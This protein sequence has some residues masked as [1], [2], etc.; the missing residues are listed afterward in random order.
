MHF[1]LKARQA[2]NALRACQAHT[3]QC[4]EGMSDGQSASSPKSKDPTDIDTE[5]HG[6]PCQTFMAQ[7]LNK[8][9]LIMVLFSVIIHVLASTERDPY[10]KCCL[11][12]QP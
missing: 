6:G 8:F 9:V 12:L 1:A 3:A 2:D 5:W 10:L 11:V 4:P 7:V